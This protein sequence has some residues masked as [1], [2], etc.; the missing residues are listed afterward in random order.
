MR[1]E[2]LAMRSAILS[3]V[4]LGGAV[5]AATS[6]C[7]AVVE[8]EGGGGSGGDGSSSSATAAS[9]TTQ[10]S[11]VTSSM[12]SFS[13]AVA[14]TG[15]GTGVCGDYTSMDVDTP[16]SGPCSG[17]FVA[18]LICFPKESPDAPCDVVTE[19]CILDAYA[20]GLQDV[21]DAYCPAPS[22]GDCC[23]TVVGDCPVGRPFVVGGHVR[24]AALERSAGWTGGQAA[25]AP[26][27]SALDAASR[28]ALADFWAREALTE[29]A[30]VASFS[31]FVLQLLA[32][33]APAELVRGAIRAASEELEHAT[34]C[35][36]LASA[37]GAEPV[38]PGALDVTGALDHVADPVAAAVSLASEGCIAET[39]SALQ[40]RVAF[41]EA[42]DPAVRAS[43]HAIAAEEAEHAR[44]AWAAL[45]WLLRR[46]GGDSIRAVAAVFERSAAHVGLGATCSHPGD[47]AAMRAHGYLALDTRRRLALEVLRDV[48]APCA[49]ALLASLQSGGAVAARAVDPVAPDA[50]SPGTITS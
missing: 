25:L 2:R 49:A 7:S 12:G 11:T 13:T 35:F 10:A 22:G 3:A 32:L 16:M 20:C 24:L 18:Q 15:G 9:T 33:G 6:G 4:G 21:G 19:T 5:V 37:Y 31:R 43:L 23:Y 28:Q 46:S 41:E 40:I 45:A 48:V 34:A 39:V 1:P 8:Q 47:A 42:T 50:S 30:S 38:R 36:R 26:D 17:F 27:V 14:S 29:H 44:L